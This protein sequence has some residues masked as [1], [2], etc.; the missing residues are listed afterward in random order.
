MASSARSVASCT[1][2]PWR[3]TSSG[4]RPRFFA[5]CAMREKRCYIQEKKKHVQHPA[6]FQTQNPLLAYCIVSSGGRA[7][8]PGS[9]VPWLDHNQLPGTTRRRI[10]ETLTLSSVTTLISLLTSLIAVIA[11]QGLLMGKTA[12]ARVLWI[13]AF[14]QVR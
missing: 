4:L 7:H 14:V 8:V 11:R 1:N 9:T 13:V 10:R 3:S 2:R 12:Q 5:T 6:Y